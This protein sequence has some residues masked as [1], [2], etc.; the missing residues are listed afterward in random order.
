MRIPTRR[1]IP[2]FL[3]APRW[4]LLPLVGLATCSTII[5][6]QAVISGA[7]SITKQAVQFGFLPRLTTAHTSST[8][9]GQIYMPA[10]NWTLMV[11][12][13]ILVLGFK[14]SSNLAAYGIVP[15]IE[16]GDMDT[17]AAPLDFL[18]INY[19]TR[20]VVRASVG[21][22]PAEGAEHTEMGWEVYPDGLYRLLV[23]L[24]T[25]YEPPE[26]YITE[27]GAAFADA[28]ENGRVPDPGGS[29]ISRGI[30]TRS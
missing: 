26:L 7:F 13:I 9:S 5:A 16:D 19:Y 17:I 29:P 28:R 2:F 1:P 18:G 11:A 8:E 30:S 21:E 27:N 24:Q 23:H 4:A 3:L 14:S 12:C 10:V 15:T 20:S 22:V 25:V 6:S